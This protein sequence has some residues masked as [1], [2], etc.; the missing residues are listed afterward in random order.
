MTSADSESQPWGREGKGERFEA[1]R[2]PVC[3]RHAPREPSTATGP[4]QDATGQH[5]AI[6]CICSET[7]PLLM[8]ARLQET[9][10]G[11]K[12]K[13]RSCLYVRN[14]GS[15][16]SESIGKHFCKQTYSVASDFIGNV[17]CCNLLVRL[18]TKKW[19]HNHRA[20]RKR[21]GFSERCQGQILGRLSRRCE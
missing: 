21:A 14:W 18:L 1:D 12:K 3:V 16:G 8:D 15:L 2:V 20:K 5:E 9:F 6:W 13:K 10:L 4:I 11:K 7:R 17:A 19:W